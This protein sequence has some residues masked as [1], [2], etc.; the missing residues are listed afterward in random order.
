MG[1]TILAHTLFSCQEVNLN[2]DNFFSVSGNS[3]AIRKFK[4]LKLTASHLL[5]H[6]DSNLECILQLR[7]DRWFRVL[8]Y[9][10]SYS[11][12]AHAYPNIDNWKDFF[13]NCE[14]D[15]TNRH[16][17]IFYTSIKDISWPECQTFDDIH[18]LPRFIQDEVMQMYQPPTW[19]I[20]TNAQLLEFL[21]M[22]YYDQL[23]QDHTNIADTPIYNLSDYYK[24]NIEPLKAISK[25]LNWSWDDALSKQFHDKMLEVNSK[26]LDWLDIMKQHH[27]DTVAGIVCP[28]ILEVWEKALL[29]AKICQTMDISPASL[30]WYN[31]D[32]SLAH[33]N[34]TIIKLLQR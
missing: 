29:I 5:E 2:L 23:C 17:E 11:K 32:C 20:N 3:H 34:A 18:K 16:W 25:V 33:D 26:Y 10:L 6:P 15:K 1:N 12:W 4:N 9:K 22:C 31:N 28:V 7:S 14:S 8:Q 30:K 19:Q 27:D 24:H 21:S 13:I